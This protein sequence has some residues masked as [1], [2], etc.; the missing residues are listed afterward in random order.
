MDQ[1]S[2]QYTVND[3]KKADKKYPIGFLSAFTGCF[4]AFACL[5]MILGMVA[6]TCQVFVEEKN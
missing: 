4:F 1:Y 6:T 5:A 2:R 3:T